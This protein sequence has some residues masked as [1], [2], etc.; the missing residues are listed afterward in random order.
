MLILDDHWQGATLTMPSG[1]EIEVDINL[2]SEHSE[3]GTFS[4]CIYPVVDGQTKTAKALL[5]VLVDE[6]QQPRS[7][8]DD[9]EEIMGKH[10]GD[11][12]LSD[13]QVEHIRVL[14]AEL[15]APLKGEDNA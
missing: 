11:F 6:R 3:P 9:L 7:F 14:E 1:E 12:D 13:E 2:C 15:D 5:S 4:L 8:W 10:F